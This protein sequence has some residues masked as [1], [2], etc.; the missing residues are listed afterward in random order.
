MKFLVRILAAVGILTVVVVS[1]VGFGIYQAVNSDKAI[2]IQLSSADF[3]QGGDFLRSEISEL[4]GYC[5]KTLS[6]SS[7]QPRENYPELFCNC[8][9]QR[10]ASFTSRFDRMYLT[11]KFSENRG[12]IIGLEITFQKYLA[13]IDKGQNYNFEFQKRT[14]ELFAACNRSLETL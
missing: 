9:T 6:K 4:F 1:Y 12:Q 7:K 8:L 14:S 3:D 2:R 11:A 13:N 5:K 10:A